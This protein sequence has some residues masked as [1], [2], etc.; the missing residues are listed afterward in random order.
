MNKYNRNAGLSLFFVTSLALSS[1]AFGQATTLPVKKV[2]S[3][4]TE[5]APP[6]A[7][8]TVGEA[9]AYR[10]KTDDTPA[11]SGGI[12]NNPIQFKYEESKKMETSNS[13][14]LE[15]EELSFKAYPGY[16]KHQV[17]LSLMPTQVTSK[18]SYSGQDYNY[19][20]SSSTAFDFSYQY[21]STPQLSI[22]LNYSRYDVSIG[23]ASV[24][25]Y[26]IKDSKAS[27]DNYG[28]KSQFCSVL[29]K[30][31]FH[32]ICLGADLGFENYPLLDFT[33]SNTLELS[34]VQDLVAGINIGYN[35][36]LFYEIYMRTKLGYNLGLGTGN[37]GELT[38][39]SNSSIYASAD[40][41]KMLKEKHGVSA[42]LEF[43]MRNA[44][45]EGLRGSND[46]SWKSSITT[47]AL[48]AGYIYQF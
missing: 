12:Q 42:G 44:K 3:K 22:A 32:Q 34:K 38:S 7:S 31:F 41:E 21:L 16:P 47:T 26:L 20:S 10:F 24:T 14:Q 23:D 1:F 13:D 18:W 6:P 39:K 17:R 43:K 15:A 40:F 11:P 33:G 35:H 45:V 4:T 5:I 48:K 29:E 46:D 8:N 9:P 27:V 37:S 28:V 2:K 25:P 30:S 36:P 19:N